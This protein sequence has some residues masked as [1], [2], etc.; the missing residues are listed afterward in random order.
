[1][2]ELSQLPGGLAAADSALMSPQVIEEALDLQVVWRQAGDIVTMPKMFTI[3]VPQTMQ[4]A[5]QRHLETP[6]LLLWLET[7]GEGVSSLEQLVH[8]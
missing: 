5:A 2:T 8:Q 4:F 7:V 3:T 6:V 1:M